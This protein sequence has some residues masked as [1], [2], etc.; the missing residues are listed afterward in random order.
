MTVQLIPLLMAGALT[1]C[2]VYMLLERNLTRTLLGLMLIGNGIN[3]LIIDVSGPGGSPPIYNS[4]EGMDT[5]ADP[6]A[7]GL[8]LTAIVITMG[9]CAFVLALTYRSY[10]LTTRDDVDDDAESTRVSQLSDEEIIA[11]DEDLGEPVPAGEL[12]AV[13]D[14]EEPR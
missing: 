10:R 3:L 12:D 4:T 11:A 2:G 13:S 14:I 6:L 5:D 8:V 9:I 1:A 7:Q